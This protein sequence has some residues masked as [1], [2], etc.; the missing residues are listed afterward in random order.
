VFEVEN[1]GLLRKCRCFDKVSLVAQDPR[2]GVLHED[3][4]QAL[5]RQGLLV[6]SQ[7][8]AYSLQVDSKQVVDL[9]TPQLLLS[10]L[11]NG[12]NLLNDVLLKKDKSLLSEGG[13][14]SLLIGTHELR[15]LGLNSARL[16][17]YLQYS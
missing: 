14:V 2:F 13:L 1:V 11:M 12:R 7:N 4:L 17:R 15:E 9:S 10:K 5:E 3:R 16:D 6:Q 8:T